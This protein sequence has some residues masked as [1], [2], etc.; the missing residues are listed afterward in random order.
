MATIRQATERCYGRE[1]EQ[2]GRCESVIPKEPAG[3][4]QVLDLIALGAEQ[5]RSLADLEHPV[6]AYLNGLAPSSRRPHLA[7]ASPTPRPQDPEPAR[8][9]LPARHGQPDALGAAR[10]VEGVLALRASRHG[11]LAPRATSASDLGPSNLEPKT[12]LCFHH[13]LA[14][15]PTTLRA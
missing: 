4:G 12:G 5:P 15:P 6:T 7:P 11:G 8:G 1:A 9:E 10:R 2:C 3:A 14:K 13:G